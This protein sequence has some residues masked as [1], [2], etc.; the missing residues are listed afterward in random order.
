VRVA[1]RVAARLDSIA[2]PRIHLPNF[3]A[4]SHAADDKLTAKQAFNFLRLFAPP[5]SWASSIWKNCIPPSHSFIFWRLAHGKMP[6]NENLRSRGCVIVSICNLCLKSIE[7]SEH[8]FL[9]CDFSAALWN[10]L[11]LNLNLAMDLSFIQ[12][13]LL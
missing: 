6:T 11:G 7:S 13:L 2:L 8:L 5:M 3:L 10:W 1:P 12:A 9:R 4:W